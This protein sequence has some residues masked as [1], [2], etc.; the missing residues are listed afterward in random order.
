MFSGFYSCSFF[1]YFALLA[2]RGCNNCNSHVGASFLRSDDNLRQLEET[3]QTSITNEA[4]IG[5]SDEEYSNSTNSTLIGNETMRF[6]DDEAYFNTTNSSSLISSNNTEGAVIDIQEETPNVMLPSELRPTSVT[7]G[8]YYYPWHGEDFHNGGYLRAQLLP[9]QGPELGEYDDTKKK[10]IQKHLE[11]SDIGGIDLWVNSW[12]GPEAPTDV[13]TQD[14]VMKLV[15][16]EAH[17]MKI[18]LLYEST[19][20]LR[21][22]GQWALDED[23]VADDMEYITKEYFDHFDNYF[24]IDGKPVL[25]IYLTRVLATYGDFEKGQSLLQRTVALMRAKA[26]TELFIVGD[27]AFDPYPIDR[28]S[29]TAAMHNSSLQVLDAITNCKYRHWLKTM[30]NNHNLTNVLDSLNSP[31]R[32]NISS[33]VFVD[34]VYGF[35]VGARNTSFPGVERLDKYYFEHQR[36]WKQ[37]AAEHGCGYI[38][39]VMP[40]FNDRGVREPFKTPLSRRLTPESREGTF[41]EASLERA[42]YLVDKKVGN[43]LMVTTFNEWHEDTQIE[44]VEIGIETNEP[45]EMTGGLPYLGYGTLYLQIL[46]NTTKGANP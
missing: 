19:N 15:E 21:V 26:K 29:A 41:F 20:R 1:V 38:P 11:F 30:E 45:V 10:T 31:P 22:N 24:T 39:S 42:F 36:L 43:L 6:E 35:L 33:Y 7:V 40:G 32:L 34:D 4:I 27:H 3:N 8:A 17:P 12:W 28:M 18:A 25:F 16:K 9:R 37:V 44:P 23:R 5:E 46:R 13:T 2:L 14:T